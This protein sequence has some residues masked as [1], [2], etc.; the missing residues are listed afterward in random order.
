[1]PP[2][3]QKGF[4]CVASLTFFLAQNVQKKQLEVHCDA[5]GASMIVGRPL[6]IQADNN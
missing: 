5:N 2:K 1:M 4:L 6:H 3:P